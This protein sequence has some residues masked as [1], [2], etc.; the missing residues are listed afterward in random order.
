[1]S[2]VVFFAA[3][4]S[5]ANCDCNFFVRIQISSSRSRRVIPPHLLCF[6]A[7]QKS[8]KSTNSDVVVSRIHFSRC[9]VLLYRRLVVV[10]AVVVV[11]VVSK[12]RLDFRRGTSLGPCWTL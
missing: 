4:E 1:M 7:Q 6:V 9:A 2:R 8:Q 10:L 11:V 5:R 3:P 12:R